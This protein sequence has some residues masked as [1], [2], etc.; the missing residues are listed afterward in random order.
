MTQSRVERNI[1]KRIRGKMI[2]GILGLALGG[3]LGAVLGFIVGH[4]HDQSRDSGETLWHTIADTPMTEFAGN[5]QQAVFTM[6]VIVLGAKMAKADGRVTREEIDTFKR[7]FGVP[8]SQ[9]ERIGRL[10][11]RARKS[12]EGFEPYAFQLAATFRQHPEVLEEVLGGLFMIAAADSKGLSAAE[13]RFL[14]R[15]GVIFGFSAAD[16]FRIAAR[17]GVHL[18]GSE[19]QPD[20]P[21]DESYAILGLN[22]HATVEEIKVAYRALI[23]KHHP[24][25]LVAQGMAPEFVASATEKMKRI[26]AAYDTI[27]KKRGIK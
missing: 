12:T 11:D 20:T 9:E 16:F 5:L 10:F 13:R 6:G 21:R 27:C 26:N 4:V 19:K 2:G 1:V 25:K 7:V 3:P 24:D 8:P 22:E 23:L 18:P 17:S 14:E 15:V